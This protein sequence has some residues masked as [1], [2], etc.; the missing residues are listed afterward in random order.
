MV[1]PTG[2]ALVTGLANSFG[3]MPPMTIHEVGYGVGT[4]DLP[5]RPNLLRILIGEQ[6]A[7]QDVDTVVVIET[8]LDDT[9]LLSGWGT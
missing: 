9:N 4:R 7:E 8:N 6:H 2:A 3:P 1:T 5:D